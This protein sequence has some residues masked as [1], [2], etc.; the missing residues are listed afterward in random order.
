MVSVCSKE[1]RL[2]VVAVI[3]EAPEKAFNDFNNL[4]HLYS[5]IIVGRMGIPYKERGIS[6]VSIIV[7]GT[8]DEIGA[9]TGKIGQLPSVSVKTVLTKI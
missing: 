6:V 4:L 9:L 7:D 8:N 5:K 1:R 3:L 2:G